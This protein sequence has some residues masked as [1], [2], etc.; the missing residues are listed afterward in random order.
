M[1]GLYEVLGTEILESRDDS[2]VVTT[3]LTDS[4]LPTGGDTVF[5]R[6]VTIRLIVGRPG[7]KIYEITMP[8]QHEVTVLKAIQA[9]ITGSLNS[10]PV[11]LFHTRQKL[12]LRK[13]TPH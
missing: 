10:I 13:M 6:Q 7:R 3:L 1:S 8:S 11:T 2:Q 12:G 4:E 5:G 9:F